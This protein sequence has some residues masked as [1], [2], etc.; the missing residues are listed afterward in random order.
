MI[1]R[2]ASEADLPAIVEIYNAT[3]P[4]RMVTADIEPVSVESRRPWLLEHNPRTRPIWAVDDP[5]SGRVCAW[6]SLSSFHSRPAYHPTAEVG[7]YVAEAHRG[8]GIGKFLLGEAIDRAP[9]CGVRTLLGLIWAHNEPS[10]QLFENFGFVRWGHLPRV[11][12]LDAVER[13]LV[14]VGRRV[15]P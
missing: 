4:G 10:L 7:L 9:A 13:D 2:D 15:A 5:A 6:L 12:E 8:H 1:L 14:I 11:A 3:I